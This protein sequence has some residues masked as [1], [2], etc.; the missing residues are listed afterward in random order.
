[1][2]VETRI[3]NCIMCPLGCEM[4]VTIEDGAVTGV[5]GNTCPRGPKYAHDEVVAPKR[6]LTSTVRVN[7]GLLPLVSVVSKNTLP[8]ERILD[9]AAALRQVIIEAPVSEGQVIVEN[10]L[11][12]GVDIVASRSMEVHQE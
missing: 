4:T 9:C 1:M 3:M 7:G 2:A 5:T 12:L 6:M 11:G 8:K 10:I